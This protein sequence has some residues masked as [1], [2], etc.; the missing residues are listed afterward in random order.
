MITFK[1]VTGNAGS[2]HIYIHTSVFSIAEFFLCDSTGEQYDTFP[3]SRHPFCK[4]CHMGAPIV[5]KATHAYRLVSLC[6]E[7]TQILFDHL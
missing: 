6:L 4:P 1:P 7:D 5:A 3:F 2:I